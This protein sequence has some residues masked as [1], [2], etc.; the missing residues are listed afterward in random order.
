M[1]EA[2]AIFS[3][4]CRYRYVLR[5][6]WLSG[7]GVCLFVCLNPSIA[8]EQTNDPTVRRCIGFS[9][10][11]GYRELSVVNIF[12]L[13][14]TNP[15]AL[16]QFPDPIGPQNDIYIRSEAERAD[17]IVVAWGNHGAYQGRSSEVQVLLRGL[18][19]KCFGLTRAGEPRH[20]LYLAKDSEL[21][22]F[23]YHV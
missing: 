4:D 9:Q 16:R 1:S 20:P 13:R 17:R 5:R 10:A 15:D 7:D 11:W 3:P 19:R 22:E 12:A 21:Q 8:D 2:P 6:Q 18:R 23:P 14:S